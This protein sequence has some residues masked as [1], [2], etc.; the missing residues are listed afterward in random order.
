M[1]R[2][3]PAAQRGRTRATWLD[4]RHSFSFGDYFDPEHV[5]FRTL[6]V[7]NEDVV[8]PG[9][10]FGTHPHRD[11]EILT[12][13][14]SGALRHEDSTG[15][16]G[17]IRPGEAQ[18]MSA[19]TG[20]RHSEVNASS[21]EPVRF[22]QIWIEPERDGLPSGYE[23]RLFPEAG[24]T[25]ALR[26]ITSRDAREG[27]LTLHQD[28]EVYAARLGAGKTIRYAPAPGRGQWLQVTGGSLT[29]GA[30]GEGGTPLAAGDGAAITDEPS[31][32][33]K[34]TADADFLLFDLA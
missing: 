20:I 26:L 23:Q 15:A 19:G 27:S 7:I 18:R 29:V 14:L 9:G 3:R 33:L 2:V 11:M 28:A 4:S 5:G 10:G 24:R 16:S 30:S 25:G 22:M 21:I 12:W 8:A 6:R 31:L 1:I 32:V 13:V 34:A 17:V